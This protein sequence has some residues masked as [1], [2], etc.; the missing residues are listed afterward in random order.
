[1]PRR[2]LLAQFSTGRARVF[3]CRFGRALAEI[4]GKRTDG[5][6]LKE[7]K[8]RHVVT[9][10]ITELIVNFDHEKGMAADIEKAFLESDAAD[11]E[12]PGP[13][14]RDL[15]FEI[16]GGAFH[17]LG[18]FLLKI[19]QGPPVEFSIGCFGKLGQENQGRGDEDLG[20]LG[21]A[22]PAIGKRKGV[23]ATKPP[24]KQ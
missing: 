16:A 10:L 20:Q 12:R 5:G 13:D 22:T 19:G 3:A 2:R 7:I 1:M 17:R 15:A 24:H 18:S 4:A 6:I 14:C 9:R 21:A 8:Q 23:A 11:P